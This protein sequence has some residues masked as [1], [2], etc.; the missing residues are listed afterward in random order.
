MG[1]D[2]Y[3]FDPATDNN[4]EEHADFAAIGDSV[5]EDKIKQS[6]LKRLYHHIPSAM[7][8]STTGDHTTVCYD[9]ESAHY[10]IVLI[11]LNFLM[12]QLFLKNL[13][14]KLT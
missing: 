5:N 4:S 11:L 6:V 10:G 14:N 9:C 2:N 12:M 7:N 13:I 8:H 1:F 3:D